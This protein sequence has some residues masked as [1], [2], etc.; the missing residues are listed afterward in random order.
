MITLSAFQC[1]TKDR[2]HQLPRWD[3]NL[4][5][6]GERN[7]EGDFPF[8]DTQPRR[9]RIDWEPIQSRNRS[10]GVRLR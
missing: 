6:V 2:L 9:K 10:D 8:R 1:I 5:E 4:R 3:D 7:L